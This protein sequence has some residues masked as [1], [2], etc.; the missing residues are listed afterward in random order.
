MRCSSFGGGGDVQARRWWLSSQ[1][2]AENGRKESGKPLEH[3][4]AATDDGKLGF[5]RKG[6][7]D[8]SSPNGFKF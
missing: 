8:E 7:D 6:G 4:M 3:Q 5:R 2:V 1:E